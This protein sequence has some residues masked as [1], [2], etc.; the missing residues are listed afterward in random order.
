VP[1]NQPPPRKDEKGFVKELRARID[2]YYQIVVR[3]VLDTIPTRLDISSS[4]SPKKSFTKIF[5]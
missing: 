5:T 2:D 4:E 1:Q 3:N